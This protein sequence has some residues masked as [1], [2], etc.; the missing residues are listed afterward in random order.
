MLAIIIPYFKIVF[1]EATLRSLA[2]QT[3]QRFKVYIGDDASPNNPQN[4]LRQFEGFFDFEYHRFESNL[5]GISLTKQWERCIA[6]SHNEP[7]LMLLGDDD[8]LGT[9]VVEEFYKVQEQNLEAPNVLKFASCTIDAFGTQIS[10]VYQHPIIEKA[11]DAYYKKYIWESRSSLSEYIFR[12]SSYLNFGFVH[13]PLAWHSDDQ[14]WLDFTDGGLIYC[15]NDALVQVR[16]SSENISG[17]KDN[18]E[19]KNKA[20]LLF[21][22]NLLQ[23][24]KLHFSKT[25]KVHLLFDFGMLIKESQAITFKRVFLVVKQFC[26]MGKLIAALRFLRRIY[27]IK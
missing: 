5:G 7:W 14:A 2:Q 23:N 1:F 15:I 10:K 8:V 11:T 17:Q 19:L 13:Y 24:T 6:L 16:L 3:D 21:F 26:F 27:W 18:L 12:R 4:L 20:S 9:N 25:Q 22:E